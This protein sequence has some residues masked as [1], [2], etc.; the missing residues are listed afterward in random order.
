MIL[1]PN[2]RGVSNCRDTCLAKSLL[3]S[4]GTYRPALMNDLISDLK[5]IHQ[6]L[7]TLKSHG[8]VKEDVLHRLKESVIDECRD[9]HMN[10]GRPATRLLSSTLDWT[11]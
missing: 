10:A 5:G 2:E 6:Q 4:G 7:L 8:Q 3:W 1:S 11:E 9:K